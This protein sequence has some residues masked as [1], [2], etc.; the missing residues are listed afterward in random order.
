MAGCLDTVGAFKSSIITGTKTIALRKLP[1][2]MIVINVKLRSKSRKRESAE[3]LRTLCIKT[4]GEGRGDA[5]SQMTI[6]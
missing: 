4:R 2:D 5:G 6:T 1:R 3:H